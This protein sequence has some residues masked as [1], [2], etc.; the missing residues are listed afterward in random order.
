MYYGSGAD[1]AGVLLAST[2]PSA[3]VAA[4][5]SVSWYADVFV[6][7][8]AT[9]ATGTLFATGVFKPNESVQ[10]ATSLLPGV[11]PLVST[12]VDLTAANI[13]SVQYNRSGATAETM[14]VHDMEVVAMN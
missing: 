9:G 13:I 3:L 11:N 1:G 12:A 14:Q 10:S 8:R 2:A 5:T 4:Q 7:C 6:H